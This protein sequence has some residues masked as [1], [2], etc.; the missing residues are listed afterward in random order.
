MTAVSVF[1][2]LERGKYTTEPRATFSESVWLVTVTGEAD[3]S[4]NAWYVVAPYTATADEAIAAV[5]DSF[6]AGDWTFSA[7]RRSALRGFSDPGVLA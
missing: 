7:E 4:T 1:K 2:C 5:R 6:Y 3:G